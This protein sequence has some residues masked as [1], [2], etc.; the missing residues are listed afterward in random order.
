[1][2]TI[3]ITWIFNNNLEEPSLQHSVKVTGVD[4]KSRTKSICHSNITNGMIIFH[5]DCT[6][7]LKGKTMELPQ[8]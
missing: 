1:M 3:N 7:E 5:S 2:H 8:I 4:E 6:H